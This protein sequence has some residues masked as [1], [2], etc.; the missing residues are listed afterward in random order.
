MTPLYESENIIITSTRMSQ[1][2]PAQTRKELKS[3]HHYKG[4]FLAQEFGDWVGE[5]L[6]VSIRINNLEILKVNNS[7]DI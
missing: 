5:M 6:D 2:S 7:R 1:E 4:N 3:G